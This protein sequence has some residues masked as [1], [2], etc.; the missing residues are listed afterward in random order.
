MRCEDLAV[1]LEDVLAGTSEMPFGE[2][3]RIVHARLAGIRGD[4]RLDPSAKA[5]MINRPGCDPIWMTPEDWGRLRVAADSACWD[6]HIIEVREIR[7]TEWRDDRDLG[8]LGRIR[9]VTD[10]ARP[11]AGA[12]WWRFR[13]G[14]WSLWRSHWDGR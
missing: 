11:P 13:E 9:A 8:E 2:A 1:L 3:R 10:D 4:A 5:A 12:G 14:E 7:Q 6:G